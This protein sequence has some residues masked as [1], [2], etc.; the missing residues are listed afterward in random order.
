M[1]KF[2]RHVE[3]VFS[4]PLKDKSEE[5]HISYLL[6]LVGEK[7]RDVHQT[8]QG[9]SEGEAK[10]LATCTDRFKLNVQPQLNP[11]S[12]KFKFNNKTQGTVCD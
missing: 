6:L 1:G 8:R 4:G 10:K 12:V 5:E 7:G 9:I 11:I 3:I 2:K